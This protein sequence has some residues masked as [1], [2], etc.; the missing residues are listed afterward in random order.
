M[1]SSLRGVFPPAYTEGDRFAHHALH[2][3]HSSRDP[4]QS[5]VRT[6]ANND[7]EQKTTGIEDMPTEILHSIVCLACSLSSKDPD[8]LE[9]RVSQET[10]LSCAGVCRKWMA[11]A[12]SHPELWSRVLDFARHRLPTL[13]SLLRISNPLLLNVGHRFAPLTLSWPD[14]SLCDVYGIIQLIY[15]SRKR[16][17]ELHVEVGFHGSSFLLH[18]LCNV[19]ASHLEALTW[20][21]RLP[22]NIDAPVHQQVFVMPKLYFKR[23][24]FRRV[25]IALQPTPCLRSLTAL[26]IYHS[27][28]MTLMEW[29]DVLRSAPH[30]RF[31]SIH[32]SIRSDG[33][34]PAIPSDSILLVDLALLTVGSRTSAEIEL[35]LCLLGAIDIPPRCGLQIA[36]L[37]YVQNGQCRVI[38][39]SKIFKMMARCHK[40]TMPLELFANEQF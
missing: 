33:L 12:A 18:Y 3:S 6:V 21:T 2:A 35:H 34:I 38:I 31:L 11:V 9:L 8:L 13:C 26:S 15:Q 7:D 24:D 5:R 28:S 10:T 36:S 16:I 30:L 39:S 40:P 22:A 19:E 23:L 14:E 17:Q 29:V 27:R 4:P 37:P 32:S 20:H 25:A 1:Y